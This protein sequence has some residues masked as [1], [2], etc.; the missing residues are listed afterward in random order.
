M[1]NKFYSTRDCAKAVGVQ[2]YQV[3]YAHRTEKIA[4]PKLKIAGKRIYQTQE[5]EAVK[6]Y[7]NQ[8]KTAKRS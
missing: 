4:E 8:R 3:V 2:E 1:E 7:F 6:A 5:V